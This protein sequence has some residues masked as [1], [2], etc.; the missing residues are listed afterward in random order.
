MVCCSPCSP[1]GLAGYALWRATEALW[2]KRDEDDE[3]K[4]SAKRF[5]SA[6]RAVFYGF[7]CVTTIRFMLNGPQE[8]G[9]GG[10]GGADVRGSS[11]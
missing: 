4:R 1:S 6:G 11:A 9:S 10:D 2:G 8:A 3:A 5:G 7:F